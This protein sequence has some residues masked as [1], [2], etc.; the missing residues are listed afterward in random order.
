[1]FDVLLPNDVHL[2]KIEHLDVAIVIA[3]GVLRSSGTRNLREKGYKGREKDK[4]FKKRLKL[5]EMAH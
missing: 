5:S 4:I 1:M 2:S 3:K